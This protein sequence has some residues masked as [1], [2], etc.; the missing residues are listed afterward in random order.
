MTS[1]NTIQS[2]VPG[3]TVC[4]ITEASFYETRGFRGPHQTTTASSAATATARRSATV[5]HWRP[6]GVGERVSV[7]RLDD[8]GLAAVAAAMTDPAVLA[9][10]RA[11]VC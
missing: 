4:G 9:P 7:G 8:A 3:Q 1:T 2:V 11:N 5:R 10:Q 6:L